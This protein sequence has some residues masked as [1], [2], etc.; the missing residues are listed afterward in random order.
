M[1]RVAVILLLLFGFSN[2]SNAQDEKTITLSFPDENLNVESFVEFV[3]A[4]LDIPLV[5]DKT[6]FSGDKSNLVIKT[7]DGNK[8]SRGELLALLNNT[9]RIKGLGMTPDRRVNDPYYVIKRIPAL[10]PLVPRGRATDFK[11]G[12]I[13]TEVFEITKGSPAEAQKYIQ[14]FFTTGETSPISMTELAGNSIIVTGFKRDMVKIEE[15]VDRIN[16]I[17][18][19]VSRRFYAAKN[20]PL[21]ELESLLSSVLGRASSSSPSENASKSTQPD[22]GLRVIRQESRNRLMLIGSERQLSQAFSILEEIDSPSGMKTEVYSPVQISAQRLDEFARALIPAGLIKRSYRSTIDESKNRL[23]VQATDDIQT[24][25]KDLAKKLDGSGEPGATPQ[26]RG[27]VQTYE[28]KNVKAQDI[29]DT[30]RAVERTTFGNQFQRNR[31]QGSLN[32]R[33][34]GVNQIQTLPNSTPFNPGF[35]TPLGLNFRL[36]E[37]LGDGFL[38][39]QTQDDPNGQRNL[40]NN[41][42]NQDTASNSIIPGE[43]QVES[44]GNKIIVVAEPQVQALY[45]ELIDQLDKRPPQVLI[46]ATVVSID[47]SDD[48][49]LG[50]EISGGD[51]VGAKRVLAFTSFGLSNVD[52]TTGALSL[53]PGI[54]FNGSLVDPDAADVVLRALANHRRARVVSAPRILVND[55]A[56]GELSSISEVPFTSVNASNTVATTSFAGFAE[57]GTTIRVLPNISQGDHVNLDFSVTVN[58]FSGTGADGVPPPRQTDDVTSQVTIPDGHTVI[59]GGLRRRRNSR[60]ENFLPGLEHLSIFRLLGGN[61]SRSSGDELLFIFLKPVILRDD[62]FRDLRFLSEQERNRASI[63]DDLPQSSPILIR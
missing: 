53:I 28:L 32:F 19:Q 44:F 34:P 63:P 13:F 21:E 20:I 22:T 3:Q 38:A 49:A 35:N 1:Y 57:A 11:T 12:D 10:R 52:A 42:L 18:A 17:A 6:L 47:Y 25:I 37:S 8:V 40:F 33:E 5:Y 43:A 51:R 24:Q 26:R 46:E 55:N 14:S 27:L 59:V 30:I 54:G 60:D 62:K 36:Q 9:L 50:I 31:G 29:L 61:Q 2:F 7:S 4:T 58:D 16:G 15:I 39:G 41:P 56:E 45:A 23:I 48:Y